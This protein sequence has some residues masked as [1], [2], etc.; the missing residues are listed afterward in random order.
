MSKAATSGG[1]AQERAAQLIQAAHD[2]VDAERHG[3]RLDLMTARIAGLTRDE[4]YAIAQSAFALKGEPVAGYKL[5]Y[6]NQ[7]IRVQM[8][9]FEPNFGRY[10]RSAL[11]LPG[12]PPPPGLDRLVHPRIEPEITV[13]LAH[14]LRG[15]AVT[16]AMAA[17]AIGTA[18]LSF[19]V[20]DT[21]YRSYQ[22]TLCDNIADGSSGACCIVGESVDL[23]RLVAADTAT[24]TLLQGADPLES[25]TITDLWSELCGNLAWLANKLAA[26]DE[27]LAAGSFVMTGALTRAHPALRGQTYQA[28][29]SGLGT[30]NHTFDWETLQ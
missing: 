21:R 9:I 2:L 26:T 8:N 18:H 24:V 17:A 4:A 23:D 19:E 13:F 6:T 5:G 7:A 27:E 30:I 22:F 15:P 16:P 29:I 14:P 25:S 11:V 20:V 12:D 10:G 1:T 28:R 3:E